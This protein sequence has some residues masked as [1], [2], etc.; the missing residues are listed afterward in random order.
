MGLWSKRRPEE[1]A[2]L[3]FEDGAIFVR[4]LEAALLA[5]LFAVG[6]AGDVDLNTEAV[7]LSRV[8]VSQHDHAARRQ[9]LF[10]GGATHNNLA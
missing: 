10:L 4:A 2:Q 5:Q 1:K 8:E 3:T 6:P 9:E 7:A